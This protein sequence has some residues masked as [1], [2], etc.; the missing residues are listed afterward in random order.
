MMTRLEA[1][2]VIHKLTEDMPVVST[3]GATSRELSSVG[4]RNN[5][6]YVVDSMGLTPSIAIGVSMGM[7]DSSAKK[8]IGIEGDGGVLMNLNALASA[9]FL[10]PEKC[11]IVILDNECFGSTG[12]QTSLAT[13]IDLGAVAEG[14][15]LQVLR[16][17]SVETMER[18]MTKAI[19]SPGPWVIHARILPGNVPGTPFLNQ[20]PV[21]VAH[22][23]SEFILSSK[24]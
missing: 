7:E 15:G 6:L 17:D 1:L 14:F 8:C 9:S 24:Q 12:G 4:R 21:V 22:E 3:C 5:T 13:K 10:K 20:D 23:F 2:T 19:D 18:T 11:V 16:A